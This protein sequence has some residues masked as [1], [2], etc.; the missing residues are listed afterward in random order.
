MLQHHV[1]SLQLQWCL[2]GDDFP[3]G[4]DGGSGSRGIF[5]LEC[6][7]VSAQEYCVRERQ[8]MVES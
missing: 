6:C 3:T 4:D 1:A 8:E 7:H 2:G 5:P